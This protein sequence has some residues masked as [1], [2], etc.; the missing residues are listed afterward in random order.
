[1]TF[2]FPHT[3]RYEY[4]DWKYFG[5]YDED[6]DDRTRKMWHE[7]VNS[8]TG[9]LYD[10]KDLPVEWGSYFIPTYTD[11]KKFVDETLKKS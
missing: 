1:L 6:P 5:D 9:K 2:C 8:R 11:F 10:Y 3:T 4:G 7:I